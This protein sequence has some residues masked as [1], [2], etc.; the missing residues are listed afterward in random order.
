[1]RTRYVDVLCSQIYVPC[2]MMTADN[3]FINAPTNLLISLLVV[4][5]H[6]L[7]D[8]RN[9]KDIMLLFSVVDLAYFK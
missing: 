6:C 8:H 7:F 3:T 9:T 1:M 4:G 5:L 2:A